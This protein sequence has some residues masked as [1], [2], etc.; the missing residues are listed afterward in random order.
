MQALVVIALQEEFEVFKE[1]LQMPLVSS[2]IPNCSKISVNNIVGFDVDLH[3]MCLRNM[4]HSK[5]QQATATVL[6]QYSFDVVYNI[7]I[8]GLLSDNFGL[9]DVAVG[10]TCVNFDHRGKKTEQGLKVGGDPYR[11]NAHVKD[12]ESAYTNK[13]MTRERKPTFK[14]IAGPLVSSNDVVASETGKNQFLGMNRNFLAVD[15]EASG[16][17]EAIFNNTKSGKYTDLWV[18]K[19]ISDGADIYK[20]LQEERSDG[21][22]RRIAMKNATKVFLKSLVYWG[23]TRGNLDQSYEVPLDHLTK[24]TNNS[25]VFRRVWEALKSGN[26]GHADSLILIANSLF[27]GSTTVEEFLGQLNIRDAGYS[28]AVCSSRRGTGTTTILTIL[29][30][31]LLKKQQN[32]VFINLE[33]YSTRTAIGDQ[34]VIELYEK[35]KGLN[36]VQYLIIDGVDE[37]LPHRAFALGK[38]ENLAQKS[39]MIT[40]YGAVAPE[41]DPYWIGKVAH[42]FNISP[43]DIESVDTKQIE[44]LGEILGVQDGHKFVETV[45]ELGQKEL[46][47]FTATTFANSISRRDQNANY[48]QVMIDLCHSRLQKEGMGSRK[49]ISNLISKAAEIAFSNFVNGHSYFS[50]YSAI[51]IQKHV[52]DINSLPSQEM[53]LIQ[54]LVKTHPQMSKFLVAMHVMS[55]VKDWKVAQKSSDK[56]PLPYVYPRTVNS[57]CK[58]LIFDVRFGESEIVDACEQILAAETNSPDYMKAHACYLLGRVT[59]TQQITHS[60]KILSGY[61]ARTNDT[62]LTSS[63]AQNPLLMAIRSAYISLANLG[64]QKVASEYVMKLISDAKW[65]QLNRGFHLEYY[66][67]RNYQPNQ[68]LEGRD[69]L[70]DWTNTYSTLKAK[71]EQAPKFDSIVIDVYT[72][73]SFAKARSL[74]GNLNEHTASELKQLYLKVVERGGLP[75]FCLRFVKAV[76]SEFES[77]RPKSTEAF[78]DIYACKFVKRRGYVKRKM[79]FGES[80]ADHTFGAC[81]IARH[82]LPDAISG[83][84]EYCKSK[85]LKMLRVH[86]WAEGRIGDFAPSD[87]DYAKK[88]SLEREFFKDLSVIGHNQ[89]FFSSYVQYA[90]IWE[91]FSD[92]KDVNATIA[93]D[94]DSLEIYVQLQVYRALGFCPE[95]YER[96]LKSIESGLASEEGKDVLRRIKKDEVHIEGYMCE[97]LRRIQPEAMKALEEHIEQINKI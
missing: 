31:M 15:M 74:T 50:D 26:S 53:A 3:V 40:I 70:G 39:N 32:A 80:V 22:D 30:Y 2:Q 77:S 9:R 7:G 24:I 60:K 33:K 96:W 51:D 72:I 4:T 34:D 69:D 88:K 14:T 86:D 82:Y 16:I 94:I 65:D 12:F 47:M 58:N 35:I 76:V 17:A 83:N 61:L 48:T 21:E 57:H 46:D 5:A 11:T 63:Q 89:N 25:H 90:P 64:D 8:A 71:L 23:E 59:S 41:D 97:N 62:N 85:I 75:D 49:E 10:E 93:R 95:D 13:V 81:E 18:F 45:R 67:D 37:S 52:V 68:P 42:R 36:S 73:F 55:V 43:I 92:G 87:K 1:E 79:L 56:T 27:A 19:G 28:C 20:N 91:E 66:G 84:V 29:Y 38:L 44:H 6:S 78:L 54:D